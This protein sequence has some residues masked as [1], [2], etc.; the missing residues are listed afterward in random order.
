MIWW[1]RWAMIFFVVGL[2]PEMQ[3]LHGVSLP[4]LTEDM[5]KEVA[6]KA[7]SEAGVNMED[8]ELECEEGTLV[9]FAEIPSPGY[10]GMLDGGLCMFVPTHKK[11]VI[12]MRFGM[13]R[14]ITITSTNAAASVEA[15]VAFALNRFKLARDKFTRQDFKA[16]K[17]V[18]Y[19]KKPHEVS[20][21]GFYEIRGVYLPTVYVYGEGERLWPPQHNFHADKALQREQRKEG[22]E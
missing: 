1:S 12:D 3:I 2:V 19:P 20:K 6:R 9:E 14:M 15:A 8:Y 21:Q 11:N 17:V 18:G 22:Q 10:L 13:Q 7:M 16:F 5:S 4:T